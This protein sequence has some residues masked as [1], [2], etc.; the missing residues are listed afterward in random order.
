MVFHIVIS[1]KQKGLISF[2]AVHI[3]LLTQDPFSNDQDQFS[4]S[5]NGLRNPEHS[6]VQVE[7]S[8]NSMG[9]WYSI[10]TGVWFDDV[11]VEFQGYYH[12]TDMRKIASAACQAL[13]FGSAFH[14]SAWTGD[15]GKIGDYWADRRTTIKNKRCVDRSY[16]GTSWDQDELVQ[17]WPA[18]TTFWLGDMSGHNIKAG[19]SDGQVCL[20]D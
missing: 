4:T 1:E 12:E 3:F 6:D 8:D 2:L 20:Y 17:C 9:G 7:G 5:V 10:S 19:T 13:C 15:R 18:G 11:C 14:G 16:D